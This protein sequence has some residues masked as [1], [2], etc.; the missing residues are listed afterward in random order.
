MHQLAFQ[1]AA[2]GEGLGPHC[3]LAGHGA[4]HMWDQPFLLF[5][6][7][8]AFLGGLYE[9]GGGGEGRWPLRIVLFLERGCSEGPS[10]TFDVLTVQY[11]LWSASSRSFFCDEGTRTSLKSASDTHAPCKTRDASALR[12]GHAVICAAS[13]ARA[14]VAPKRSIEGMICP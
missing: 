14:R 13:S 2:Q 3:A 11:M 9:M 6:Q 1:H 5:P 8:S 10:T 12:N 4:S 7:L